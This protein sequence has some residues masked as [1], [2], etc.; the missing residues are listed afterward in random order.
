M[1]KYTCLVYVWMVYATYCG[2]EVLVI[3]GAVVWSAD[4]LARIRVSRGSPLPAC[5]QL[6]HCDGLF[7]YLDRHVSFVKWDICFWLQATM[8]KTLRL[9]VP[10]MSNWLKVGYTDK[11]GKAQG[12]PFTF[13]PLPLELRDRSTTDIRHSF[14]ISVGN[15]YYNYH[16]PLLFMTCLLSPLVHHSLSARIDKFKLLLQLTIIM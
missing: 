7:I 6:M 9:A 13:P 4:L 11:D 5:S 15:N 1:N 16:I 12:Q 2:S 8:I 3:C 14:M 10:D